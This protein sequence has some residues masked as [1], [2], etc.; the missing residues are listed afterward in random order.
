MLFFAAGFALAAC[1]PVYSQYAFIATL[2][3]GSFVLIGLMTKLRSG[4]P[5]A[6]FP[7]I[8]MFSLVT[9]LGGLGL[10]L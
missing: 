8:P 5:I 9:L 3:A 6:Q 10:T 7:V 1:A 2:G 4:L